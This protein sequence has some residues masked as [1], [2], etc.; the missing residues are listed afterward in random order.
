V[1]PMTQVFLLLEPLQKSCVKSNHVV[2]HMSV[3]A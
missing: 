3:L 2:I 1:V